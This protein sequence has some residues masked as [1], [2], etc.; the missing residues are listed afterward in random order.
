MFDRLTFYDDTNY[1]KP[2]KICLIVYFSAMAFPMLYR[3]VGM[4]FA[5]GFM[6]AYEMPLLTEILTEAAA[7]IFGMIAWCITIVGTFLLRRTT[8]LYAIGWLCHALQILLGC[9]V[10][11]FISSVYGIPDFPVYLLIMYVLLV[12]CSGVI[13]VMLFLGKGNKWIMLGAALLGAVL[14]YITLFLGG[15]CFI[16]TIGVVA[17]ISWSAANVFGGF[18]LV[19]VLIANTALFASTVLVALSHET[20]YY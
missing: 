18:I 17:P 14:F 16:G 10:L 11:P 3:Y 8:K 5:A 1:F 12:L 6:M 7:S 19:C 2:I 9:I 4:I 13:G 15:S 20:T